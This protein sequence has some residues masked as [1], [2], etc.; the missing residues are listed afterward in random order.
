MGALDDDSV[1]SLNDALRQL[2]A[3]PGVI[4][5]ELTAHNF[6]SANNS[7]QAVVECNGADVVADIAGADKANLSGNKDLCEQ[8]SLPPCIA[9]E[10]ASAFVIVVA[11]WRAQGF[12]TWTAL[13]RLRAV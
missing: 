5:A 12:H 11:Q 8:E 9:A 1:E 3:F 4:L 10:L 7:V 6:V 2:S 13:R